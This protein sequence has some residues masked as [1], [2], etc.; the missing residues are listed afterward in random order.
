MEIKSVGVVGAGTMGNGIAQIFALG[1]FD[2]IMRDIKQEFVDRGMKTVQKNLERMATRGKI[3]P[4]EKDAAL[5]RIT[6]TTKIDPLAD[7]DLVVEAIIEDVDAKRE[8]IQVLDAV[9]TMTPSSPPTRRPFP[10]PRSRRRQSTLS[11]SAACTS[12][13]RFRSCNW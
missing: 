6:T 5:G 10:S 1:G 9:V 13:I 8:L 7:R 12:S 2:V 3:S 11:G 4:E